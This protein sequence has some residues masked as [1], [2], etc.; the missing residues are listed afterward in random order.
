[1]FAVIGY[2]RPDPAHEGMVE[3]AFEVRSIG[4]FNGLNCANA[5]TPRPAQYGNTSFDVVISN[6]AGDGTLPRDWFLGRT[7]RA[8]WSHGCL[9]CQ[10]NIAMAGLNEDRLT[11]GDGAGWECIGLGWLSY[12]MGQFRSQYE[13]PYS[14]EHM[15]T[16]ATTHHPRFTSQANYTIDARTSCLLARNTIAKTYYDGWD[17]SVR[18]SYRKVTPNEQFMRNLIAKF[19]GGRPSNFI[20][21]FKGSRVLNGIMWNDQHKMMHF[22]F[23]GSERPSGQAV[24]YLQ[25]Y[26]NTAEKLFAGGATHGLTLGQRQLFHTMYSHW[27]YAALDPIPMISMICNNGGDSDIVSFAGNQFVGYAMKY[28]LLECPYLY[29]NKN[30]MVVEGRY[31]KGNQSSDLRGNLD[32]E[33][34]R[35]AHVEKF[36]AIANALGKVSTFLKHQERR[37]SIEGIE[38]E[39]SSDYLASTANGR[40]PFTAEELTQRFNQAVAQ[41]MTQWVVQNTLFNITQ[42]VKDIKEVLHSGVPCFRPRPARPKAPQLSADPMGFANWVRQAE[43]QRAEPQGAEDAGIHAGVFG[44][45]LG[46]TEGA[47]PETP[48]D[49]ILADA[50]QRGVAIDAVRNFNRDAFGRFATRH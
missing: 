34:Q 11:I 36:T 39:L 19:G 24:S 8:D 1:M 9:L 20:T 18:T 38:L 46:D 32:R 17:G 47:Q 40:T 7:Y 35:G 45:T 13:N 42:M 6:V 44:T 33:I 49:R 30:S 43:G 15:G 4:C 5:F 25:V 21:Y 29:G 23:V 28:S 37:P 12:E 50:V 22:E 3:V 48:V 16:W 2:K 27:A 41:V 31:N 10:D 26:R 14:D